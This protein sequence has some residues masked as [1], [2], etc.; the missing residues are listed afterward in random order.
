MKTRMTFA[1][2]MALS[3][4]EKECLEISDVCPCCCG[5]KIT[6]MGV[7]TCYDCEQNA[8]ISGPTELDICDRNG[9]PIYT[10]DM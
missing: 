1:E 4:F 7:Y 2:V 9:G 10:G 5:S 6:G 3:E 8:P